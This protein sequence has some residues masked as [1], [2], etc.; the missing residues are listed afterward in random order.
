MSS[1]SLWKAFCAKWRELATWLRAE[2]QDLKDADTLERAAA[3]WRTSGHN[4]SWLLEGTRLAEAETL[5]A[6]P[7]FCNR[8]DAI[9]DF[10]HASRQRENDRIAA[11]KQHQEVELQAAKK[12]AAAEAAAKE[13]AQA[14][15][16]VLHK[17]SRFL[18]IVL[19][20]TL[21][22]AGAAAYGF[23]WA[24]AERHRADMRTREAIASRL[25]SEAQSILAGSRAGGDDRAPQQLLAAR[26]LAPKPD[27][28]ALLDA[29][30]RRRDEL[31]IME[32][33]ACAT[34]SAATA[35][36]SPTPCPVRSVA[37]SPDGHRILVGDDDG[38]MRWWDAG[39]GQPIGEP[40]AGHSKAV[41]SVAVSRDG[42]YVA[43]GSDDATVLLWNAQ[44]GKQVHRPMMHNDVVR[45]V[46]FNRAGDLIVS[47]GDDKTIRLWDTTSGRQVEV[48]PMAHD[49]VVRSVAFNVTGDLIA[50]GGDDSLLCIWETSSGRLVGEANA[51][52]EILS[53]AFRP[54]G[55]QVVSG[56][57]DGR[58]QL[59]DAPAI[60]TVGSP[61][62]MHATADM[63]GHHQAVQSVAFSPDGSRIVSGGVDS[64][65]R[66]WET[67]TGQ[68]IGE[69]LTG[70]TG[71]VWGVAFSHDGRR[72]VSGGLD[73]TVREWDA[74]AGLPIP[75]GQG[76]IH[77]VAVSPD[78]QR[79]ASGGYDG[80]IKLWSTDT[81][82][83]IGQ[84]FGDPW[85]GNEHAVLTVAFSPDGSQIVSGSRHGLVRV[86]DVRTHHT[87][88]LPMVGPP[89][90]GDHR[91]VQ[92]VTFSKDGSRI[93]SGGNDGVVRL[94]DA[95]TH[96]SLGVITEDD[97]HQVWS[98]AF[99]PDGHR[100]I[101]AS[102]ETVEASKDYTVRTGKRTL[103]IPRRE[104]LL[105][106]LALY[107][108][109]HLVPTCTTSCRVVTT[110]PYGF[111]T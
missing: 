19:A 43:S 20:V 65:V 89:A 29:A 90:T 5:A 40:M 82:Q 44:T 81:G 103:L 64:T 1:R 54:D 102:N 96:E 22:V 86:W 88:D 37:F 4:E 101:A 109:S 70:H 78:G 47:G 53:V 58:V 106:T 48:E 69:A 105:V 6:K 28:N 46:A 51:G 39:T 26:A 87:S 66:V 11:E 100:I 74:I 60:Q 36:S 80:T 30:V 75:A 92:S 38:V 45:S 16:L 97:H 93:A 41:E 24:N 34:E 83:P 35:R 98:V 84:P 63:T 110:G 12:L 13:E 77:A 18:R 104:N 107:T 67:K 49:D 21:L 32:M 73:G 9:L 71:Q 99:S 61:V 91:F 68:P 31:K 10:L 59:W 3:D 55:K 85:P 15:A 111:G 33:P 95:K 56:S 23:V 76:K 50:S 17:R 8:L 62:I 72:I 2:S 57:V 25:V 14:H 27:S 42:R 52:N 94:W 79:I 108:A 7:R